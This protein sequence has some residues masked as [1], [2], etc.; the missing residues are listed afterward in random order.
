MGRYLTLLNLSERAIIF[1]T[2]APPGKLNYLT[3]ENAKA[4]EI[5]AS[6]LDD[7]SAET[8]D[9]PSTT[10]NE[11]TEDTSLWSKQGSW[12]IRVDQT[13]SNSCFLLAQWE[14]G[15]TLRIGLDASDAISSYFFIGHED[16]TSLKIGAKYA[17]KMEFDDLGAWDV[18]AEG[19]VIGDKIFLY[20]AFKDEKFWSEFTHAQ[21]FSISYGAREL[22]KFRLIGSKAAFDEMITC[23]KHY[24]KVKRDPFSN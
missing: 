17:L 15:L 2:I 11:K 8:N 16:W 1:A 7:V 20:S 5:E 6:A 3:L 22:G 14:T 24:L 21:G 18:P 10:T 4:V 19:K 13:M 23:Q 9:A 12:I